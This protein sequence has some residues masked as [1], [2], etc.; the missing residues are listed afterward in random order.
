MI[1]KILMNG[2]KLRLILLLSAL[3]IVGHLAFI[4]GGWGFF[5]KTSTSYPGE[6]FNTNFNKFYFVT[7]LSIMGVKNWMSNWKMWRLSVMVED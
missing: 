5:I 2:L 4:M 7:F 1:Y 3:M 6:E